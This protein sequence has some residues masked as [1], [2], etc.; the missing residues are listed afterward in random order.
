MLEAARDGPPST[1]HLW[2]LHGATSREDMQAILNIV[3]GMEGGIGNVELPADCMAMEA[4]PYLHYSHP[5]DLPAS[6]YKSSQ[7]V[8][9]P[10]P[11]HHW[12]PQSCT[13]GSQV[14]RTVQ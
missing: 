14:A 4:D 11:I 2:N 12:I 9:L 7:D 5:S 3:A 8:V 6:I 13:F 10:G 1:A